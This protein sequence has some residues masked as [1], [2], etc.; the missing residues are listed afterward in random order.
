MKF[1][2]VL[3]L[4]LSGLGWGVARVRDGSQGHRWR[5]HDGGTAT[6]PAM[7]ERDARRPSAGPVSPAERSGQD[8]GL[9]DPVL[10]MIFG[11]FMFLMSWICIA[12][13]SWKERHVVSGWEHGD[14]KIL[15]EAG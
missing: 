13:A 10:L 8:D 15:A 14:G 11:G 9:P 5:G 4:L 3:V 7:G 12:R 6:R 2:V 1:L